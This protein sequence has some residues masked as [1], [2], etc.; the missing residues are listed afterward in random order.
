MRV[1]KHSTDTLTV[2]ADYMEVI[3]PS[4]P[5]SDIIRVTWAENNVAV[6]QRVNHQMCKKV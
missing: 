6:I 2:L 5:L 1:G 4:D 3:D